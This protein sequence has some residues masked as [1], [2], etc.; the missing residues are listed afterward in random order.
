[1]NQVGMSD[2]W[3]GARINVF[4]TDYV[5]DRPSVIAE[6]MEEACATDVQGLR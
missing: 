5:F 1:M 3:V 2:D 4:V 6:T